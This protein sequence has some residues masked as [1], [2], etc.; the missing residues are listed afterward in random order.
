MPLRYCTTILGPKQGMLSVSK[1]ISAW[2]P[3]CLPKL[4][5]HGC[6]LY[7][8]VCGFRAVN[9]F[10][11]QKKA[12]CRSSRLGSYR[13]EAAGG[14][15]KLPRKDPKEGRVPCSLAVQFASARSFWPSRSYD[16]LQMQSIDDATSRTPVATN[17]GLNH[18]EVFTS[19]HSLLHANSRPDRPLQTM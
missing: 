14:H 7:R 3:A 6:V 5:R 17:T 13:S 11:V 19:S 18:A 9:C 8:I 2:T 4:H 15:L 1:S 16:I 10:R 12:L